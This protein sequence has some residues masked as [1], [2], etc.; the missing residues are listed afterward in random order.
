[1]Q[2]GRKANKTKPNQ[3]PTKSERDSATASGQSGYSVVVPAAA[4]ASKLTCQLSV[5]CGGVGPLVVLAEGKEGMR[6]SWLPTAN[7]QAKLV[8]RHRI[9]F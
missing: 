5:G 7:Y 3:N 2:H 1:V 6:W 4:K 8:A 9:M